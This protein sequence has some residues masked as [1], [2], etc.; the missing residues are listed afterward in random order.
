MEKLLFVY[1]VY[2]KQM[3]EVLNFHDEVRGI[4]E[5]HTLVYLLVSDDIE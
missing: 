2:G 4:V 1:L 5:I 3:Q